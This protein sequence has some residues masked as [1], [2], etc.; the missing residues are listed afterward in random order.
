MLREGLAAF[1]RPMN[2]IQSPAPPNGQVT[3]PSVR[4][5]ARVAG[6]NI[7]GVLGLP[8][9]AAAVVTLRRGPFDSE[10]AADLGVTLAAYLAA[11]GLTRVL[12]RRLARGGSAVPFRQRCSGIQQG[13]VRAFDRTGRWCARRPVA[14]LWLAALAGVVLSCYPVVF[15]GKS[16]V[17]PAICGTLLYNRQPT[18]PGSTETRN[19]WTNGADTAACMLCILPYS[20]IE[21]R[22]LFHDGE[23]PLWNRHSAG[24]VPLLGQGQ[25]MLADPLHWLV[26]FA[27]GNGWAWDLKF[28]VAKLLF[29]A[30]I[31]F[32]V[33]TATGGRLFAAALLAFSACFLGF[34]IYRFNHPAYFSE[35]Y[36]PWILYAWLGLARPVPGGL[37]RRALAGWLGLLLLA[38]WI[39]LGSGAVKEAVFLLLALNAAGAL[40]LVLSRRLPW[41]ER[42][43]RLLLAGWTGVCFALLSAPLWL[44]FLDALGR[45]WNASADPAASQ[46]PPGML[47]GLFDDI[48]YRQFAHE[49]NVVSPAMNFLILLGLALA[50]AD[51]KPLARQGLWV[52]LA[53]CAAGLAALVFGV[54]PPWLVVKV[55]VLANVIHVETTFSCPLIILLIVLAGGGLQ[56]AHDRLASRDWPLHAV[57]AVVVMALAVALFLGMTQATPATEFS[58]PPLDAHSPRP[59]FF[60]AYLTTLAGAYAAL[61]FLWRNFCL[62]RGASAPGTL[63]WVLLCLAALLWRQGLQVHALGVPREYVLCPPARADFHAPSRVVERIGALQ[64]AEPGRSVGFGGNLS[65]GFGG[66]LGL[67]QPSAADALQNRYF[68]RLVEDSGLPLLYGWC[69]YTPRQTF[70]AHRAFYDMLNIRYYVDQSRPD[71][72]VTPVPSALR[73]VAR[74]DLDLWVSDTA[75]PRAF[76]TDALMECSGDGELFLRLERGD[77]RPFA[78]VSR[79]ELAARP[80]LQ[81]LAARGA[82]GRA[83]MPATDYRLTNHTT[84]FRVRATGPGVVTVLEAFQPEDT[85]VSINGEPA[86]CFRVNEAFSGVYLDRAGDYTVRLRYWPRR[87]TTALWLAALGAGLL[88]ITAGMLRR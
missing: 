62:S 22:A 47:A 82:E 66:M 10:A 63:P 80:G 77:G 65:P 59:P 5:A 83:M 1:P 40:A 41:R 68:H 88:G 9:L 64:L 46:L 45:S 43:R 27:G 56:R 38:D 71:A 18:L 17:G 76:F 34:F 79:A 7:F 54:V 15:L 72:S 67:E 53:A 26:L 52:A 60:W 75:W 30:G 42:F 69:L 78:A 31:G 74:D 25:S 20:A 19:E 11:A 86:E 81:A 35:C 51:W 50:I 21:R 14:T 70:A 32:T 12:W 49:A 4:G 61:P 6:A 24:G 23:W 37:P 39:E 13:C 85:R 16:F 73:L 57:G 55:P 3:P 58:P 33:R 28:L 87:L 29:A 48:F 84:S 44:T 2:I 36:A 8:T